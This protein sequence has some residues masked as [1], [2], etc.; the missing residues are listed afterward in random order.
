MDVVLSHSCLFVQVSL[1][2]SYADSTML[3]AVRRRREEKLGLSLVDCCV[4]AIKSRSDNNYGFRI[5]SNVLCYL[6]D[7]GNCETCGIPS[8]EGK[9]LVA[10]KLGLG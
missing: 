4:E 7:L 6:S 2:K 3:V 1:M 8:D 9:F 5:V 10:V